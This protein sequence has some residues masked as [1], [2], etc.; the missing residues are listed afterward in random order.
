MLIV[1]DVGGTKTRVAASSDGRS[2]SSQVSFSTPE[3]FEAGLIKINEAIEQFRRGVSIDGIVMGVPGTVERI[4]GKTLVLPNLHDWDNRNLTIFFNERYGTKTLVANDA[5]LSGLGEAVYGQG[6]NQRI[7]A[8]LTI[9]TGIGG[10][11][12][13]DKKPVIRNFNTEP[14]HIIIDVNSQVADGSG[15]KGTLEAY[16]SGVGFNKLYNQKP[17]DCVDDKV[18]EEFV[19]RLTVGVT[20]IILLWS[21]EILIL[22]GGFLKSSDKFFEPLKKSVRE[23]LK[24]F[25][26]P[27]IE[28]AQLG[29]EA[30]LLGGIALWARTS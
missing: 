3:S 7:V 22:G 6:K 8:Y 28:L 1:V 29:D 18:W 21:P 25:P 16:C 2:I 17:E 12:I 9:S 23:E 14:G 30:G 4:S 13:V 15:R 27:F 19:K 5:E 24:L 26:V 10:A 11:L 20:N